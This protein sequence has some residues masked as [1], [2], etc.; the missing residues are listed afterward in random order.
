MRGPGC[1]FP[2][3]LLGFARAGVLIDGF[4]R[5]YYIRLPGR[6]L[7]PASEL[8]LRVSSTGSFF[9]LRTTYDIYLALDDN[10]IEPLVMDQFRR[11]GSPVREE[12]QH[13]RQECTNCI[14]LFF[15]K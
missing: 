12:T 14:R 15:R 9:L 13:R 2:L 8:M 11:F 5:I 6:A 7:V 4:H 3:L 1:R 10:P